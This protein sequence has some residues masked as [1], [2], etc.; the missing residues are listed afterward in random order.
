MIT[1]W[2]KIE[3]GQPLE[4]TLP[5]ISKETH[6]ARGHIICH[7]QGPVVL[8]DD[9]ETLIPAPE[10]HQTEFTK[11][12]IR[13]ACR[14]FGIEEKLDSI[15]ALP[16]VDRMWLEAQTLDLND[17]D[18]QRVLASALECGLLTQEDIDGVKAI[19]WG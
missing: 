5:T 3:G 4:V 11:Y 18:M 16:G 1:R 6:E 2:F 9:G 7:I 13:K 12:Q 14:Q 10:F 19:L 15:L 17:P 8:D